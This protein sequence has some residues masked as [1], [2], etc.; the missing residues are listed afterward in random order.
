MTSPWTCRSLFSVPAVSTPNLVQLHQPNFNQ[1]FSERDMKGGAKKWKLEPDNVA[2]ASLSLKSRSPRGLWLNDAG[3]SAESHVLAGPLF[4][5]VDTEHLE[6]FS[7][8]VFA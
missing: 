5:C 2:W 7:H 1:H 4:L 3:C 6:G 8:G